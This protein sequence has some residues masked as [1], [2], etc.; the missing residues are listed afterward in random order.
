MRWVLSVVVV[1]VVLY[2]AA[3]SY[4]YVKQREFFFFPQGEVTALSDIELDAKEITL[5]T[6]EGETVNGWYGAPQEGMPIIVYMK[7][8]TGSFT[9]EFERFQSFMNDGYGFVA[10]D[11]RGFP[12]SPGEITQEHVLADALAAYDFAAAQGAPVI[13]W[14]W[15]LGGSP[16]VYVSS[17][18]DPIAVVLETPFY[19][20][21]SL[22]QERY[23]FAPIGLLMKDKFPSNEWVVNI[24]AP[25]FLAHGTIDDTVPMTQGQRLYELVPNKGGIW[26]E[27]GANHNSMWERGIWERAKAFFKEQNLVP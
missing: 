2:G 24:K 26:I 25:V 23:P 14:G 16:A 9:G 4:L 27:E 6:S 15:S 3:L 12:I 20:A 18:R 19:S 11:Y 1:L 17:Q 21:E 13:V 22:A 5:P 8:N 10:V 7:G